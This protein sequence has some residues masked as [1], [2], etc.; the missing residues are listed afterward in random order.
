[1]QCA[2]GPHFWGP[3]YVWWCWPHIPLW[4]CIWS[5][6]RW[7]LLPTS[8]HPIHP[9][10]H[11]EPLLSPSYA[12]GAEAEQDVPRKDSRKGLQQVGSLSYQRNHRNQIHDFEPGI[13]PRTLC[14]IIILKYSKKEAKESSSNTG[15]P[16]T[17]ALLSRNMWPSLQCYQS[18]T[19]SLCH[20][21][22]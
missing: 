18:F 15:A 8:P 16:S 6:G 22:L 14:G 12:P 19:I 5:D 3:I 2:T 13:V 20:E 10:F 17:K 7:E 4:S 21:E 9:H 11:S 1:M